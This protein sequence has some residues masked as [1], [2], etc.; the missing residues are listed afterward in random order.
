MLTIR[1]LGQKLL[2]PNIMPYIVIKKNNDIC[3]VTYAQRYL[4][5][6]VYMIDGNE[7]I[8]RDVNLSWMRD[9]NSDRWNDL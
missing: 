6:Q 8:M 4:R 3:I 9:S 1:A 7:Y 2:A 5:N